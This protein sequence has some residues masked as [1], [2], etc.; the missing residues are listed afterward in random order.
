[1]PDA[2]LAMMVADPLLIRRPLMQMGDR[3]QAGF[4]QAG[5]DAWIGLLKTT[6]PVTDIC[7]K[8]HSSH[9]QET[10]T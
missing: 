2:V 3:R 6:R 4:D 7:L 1:M 5:V 9:H 8:E 10:S